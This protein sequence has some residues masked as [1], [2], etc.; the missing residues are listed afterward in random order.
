VPTLVRL[1]ARGYQLL[2]ISPDPVAFEARLLESY[3]SVNLAARIARLERVLLLR[4][5]RQAGIQIVD[6]RVDQ[7][8]DQ[9]VH[10]SLGRTPHWFRAV[11]MEL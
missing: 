4:K 5:L 10:A 2:V 11:G 1:R 3:P 7:P 6:W 8:F 9:V